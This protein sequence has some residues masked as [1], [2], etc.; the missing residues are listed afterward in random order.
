MRTYNY[1]DKWQK[2]LT[3]EIVGLLTSIHEYKGEQTLFIETKPD[4]LTHLLEIAKVQ[5][6]EASNKI[7]GIYT[8]D[9]RIKK[10]VNEKTM[11]RTR[12]EQEIAGYRDVLTTIHE[13]HD[14]IQP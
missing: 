5:S 13:S 3:P 9:D 1:T 10:L 12:S 2:L 8:S 7:E 4:V 11:P 6:T 14:Y